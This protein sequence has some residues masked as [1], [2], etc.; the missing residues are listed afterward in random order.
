MSDQMMEDTTSKGARLRKQ[1]ALRQHLEHMPPGALFN[2]G[3]AAIYLGVSTKTMARMRKVKNLGPPFI[4]PAVAE[5][6]ERT[7]QPVKYRKSELDI[8][9][10]KRISLGGFDFANQVEPWLVNAHGA[11]EGSALSLSIEELM[12]SE[13]L[14]ATLLD[15]MVEPWASSAAMK[16]Y[17]DELDAALRQ[18]MA[19]VDSNLQTLQME[20]RTEPATGKPRRGGL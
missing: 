10:T 9:I 7:T 13:P 8:H 19:Q 14:V 17:R 5:G 3:M 18:V 20:E 1:A 4:E 15:A 11:I 2:T 16:P 12:E 6:V